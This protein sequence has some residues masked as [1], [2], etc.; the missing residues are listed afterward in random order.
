V[1]VA[2]ARGCVSVLEGVAF[3]GGRSTNA[4]RLRRKV[5]GAAAVYTITASALDHEPSVH[6]LAVAVVVERTTHMP[7]PEL[8]LR[9]RFGLTTREIDVIRLLNEGASNQNVA[10]TLHISPATARHHTES[11][12]LKLG[13]HARSRIPALLS[14]LSE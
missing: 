9:R 14:T 2:A 6:G 4:Q 5:P 11:V 3:N 7:F 10:R 1:I 12:M 13:I 8:A